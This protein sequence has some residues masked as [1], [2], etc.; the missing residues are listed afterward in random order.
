MTTSSRRIGIVGTGNMGRIH[1]RILGDMGVLV[2]VA[3][4]DLSTAE[5][6]AKTYNVK[7]FTDFESMIEDTQPDGVVIATP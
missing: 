1:A 4:T 6:V 2:G 5:Q 7:A 3:D